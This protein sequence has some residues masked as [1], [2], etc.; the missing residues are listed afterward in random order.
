MIPFA[1]APPKIERDQ[2]LPD[3]F[4]E[5]IRFAALANERVAAEAALAKVKEPDANL[6]SI[7]KD[8]E[9]SIKFTKEI[10]FPTELLDAVNSKQER[11]T[12]GSRKN[13]ERKMED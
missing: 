12:K 5:M 10:D 13:E 11:P 7:L 8:T 1:A 6:V 9:V 4:T 3:Y 2:A